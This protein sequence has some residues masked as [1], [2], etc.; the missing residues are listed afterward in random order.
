MSQKERVELR[1][2][3]W[4]DYIKTDYLYR[5][6]KI[7]SLVRRMDD[8]RDLPD[9]ARFYTLSS[10]LSSYFNDLIETIEDSKVIENVKPDT[11]LNKT[12]DIRRDLP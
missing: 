5:S 6:K 9:K 10:L 7:E 11:K 8:L 12:E 1:K 4:I 3:F 2:R